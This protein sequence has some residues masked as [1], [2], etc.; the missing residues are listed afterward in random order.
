MPAGRRTFRIVNQSDRAVEWEILDGVMVVAE[1]ENIAPGIT[2]TLTAKLVPGTYEITCGL[3]SNPRGTLT[4]DR[5]RR[6]GRGGGPP[7]DHA[8]SSGRWRSTSSTC[9]RRATAW[10]R[11]R[12]SFTDAIKAGDLDRARQLYL[13]AR[14]A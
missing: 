7:A 4:V 8:P 11:R 1:R 3:L 13:P 6:V 5:V 12:A 9:A 14:L 10:S 2:Q